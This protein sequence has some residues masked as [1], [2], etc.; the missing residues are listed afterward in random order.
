MLNEKLI[1]CTVM[2]L[3]A[4]SCNR[5]TD[6]DISVCLPVPSGDRVSVTMDISGVGV[7]DAKSPML[8]RSEERFSGAE[9]YVYY[10]DNG[11]LDSVQEIPL[12]AF[13]GSNGSASAVLS[14][15]AGR[16]VR[17]YVSG[18]LWAVS[19]TD[20]SICGLGRALGADFPMRES[21]FLSMEYRFD[22]SDLND[23]FRYE[24]MSEVAVYGIPFA[25]SVQ[26]AE[27]TDKSILNV[28][29]VR[30]FAKLSLTV[31]HSALDGSGANPE[32][33][34]NCRLA[35]RQANCRILPFSDS[36]SLA[37]SSADVVEGDN[38]PSMVD[39]SSV[40]FV[41]YVPENLQGTLLPDNADQSRKT[42]ESLEAL[43]GQERERLLTY[44][45]FMGEVNPDAGG[46]GGPV[47][48]R[49]YLGEDN[50]SNFDIVRGRRYDI[51]LSFNVNSLFDPYWKVTPDFTDKR[52]IG[53]SAFPDFS[54]S[55][56]IGQNVVVRCNRPGSMFL[57]V[58][59]GSGGRRAPDGIVD[60][61]YRPESLSDCRVSTN[62]LS[63]DGT[64]IS[65]E[66]SALGIA[67]SFDASSGKL[68]FE[69]TDASKFKSGES[70]KM[71]VT[72]Q[73]GGKT[74]DFVISTCDDISIIW[75]KSLTEGFYP[76]MKR[77]ASISGFVG[78]L[79][80]TCTDSHMFKYRN[81]SG[82]GDLITGDSSSSPLL[83]NGDF[84]VYNYY[85]CNNSDYVFSF[86]SSDTFNDGPPVKSA[87]RNTMP[88]IRISGLV[89]DLPSEQIPIG[90][91]D[92]NA[93][94]L[95]ITGAPWLLPISVE[96]YAPGSGVKLDYSDFDP[97]A[98]SH[99]Y[100]PRLISDDNA[101]RL[102]VDGE[103]IYSGSEESYVGIEKRQSSVGFP[104]FDVFRRRIG[105]YFDTYKSESV[106]LRNC[107]IMMMPTV[108]SYYG[109]GFFRIYRYISIYLRPFMVGGSE[110]YLSSR[111]DDY[112]LWKSEHL[113]E[114]YR[115][116]TEASASG[117]GIDGSIGF[118]IQDDTML[119]LCAVPM[120]SSSYSYGEG[121]ESFLVSSEKKPGLPGIMGEFKSLRLYFFDN[122][123]NYH[124]A[125]PHEIRAYVTNRHSKE[126][127]YVGLGTTDVFVHFIVGADYDRS[128]SFYDGRYGYLS[129][130]PKIRS[131]IAR[132]SFGRSE[133]NSELSKSVE[134]YSSDASVDGAMM[135]DNS[136][137]GVPYS[138]RIKSDNGSGM[139]RVYAYPYSSVSSTPIRRYKVEPGDAESS[140][141]VE[142]LA[143]YYAFCIQ[144]SG[145]VCQEFS[146]IARAM[147]PNVLKLKFYN[148]KNGPSDSRVALDE[149][150]YTGFGDLK[151]YDGRNER[152]YYIFHLL[153][154][155]N[156]ESRG[157]LPYYEW[158]CTR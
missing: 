27:Y 76:G 157:W 29:C 43:L 147:G 69:V 74:Y 14:F 3:I 59:A 103:T 66:L 107:R 67:P 90:W 13:D 139:A 61:G 56:P 57:F 104:E 50:C 142:A 81:S 141:A 35:L 88:D 87:V 111:Y 124:S 30:L 24:K 10:S 91:S 53:M 31:D 133:Y 32:Y 19:K 121:S 78:E 113:D 21:D 130:V 22:G 115:G 120:K 137:T 51:T 7:P 41:F 36:G 39:G 18:C 116:L 138:Y 127:R 101:S 15:P 117:N 83:G 71:S 150:D 38:D 80:V 89:S 129:I 60:E 34:K 92:K 112:T 77:T 70:V 151:Y 122:G 46:Y 158:I 100:S 109:N 119:R 20:G 128:S 65:K 1:G 73:P 94:Y 6:A 93:M 99:V 108:S 156:T 82:T 95:D 42:R 9:V 49:F 136:L 85:F 58:E 8:E 146:A 126:T 37:L 84:D 140:D 12:S 11:L 5:I 26:G 72:I 28:Q 96:L 125:G 79:R 55:L 25:G 155:L 33:F 86:I 17:V 97:T 154:D 148:T 63:S 106:R 45:E 134:M 64:L 153:S 143:N 110:V 145:G 47:T 123:S 132:T 54:S 118:N 62:F 149:L 135:L 152:G 48:Y 16:N 44:V 75:N 98:F 23:M 131:D 102:E 144:S 114:P 105:D 2:C 68:L 40:S 4:L 52:K